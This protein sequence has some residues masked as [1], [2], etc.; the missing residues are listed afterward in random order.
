MT[1]FLAHFLFL[2]AAWTLVIKFLLPVVW[3]N[4]E[5]VPLGTYIYWDFWWAVHIWL[6]LAL[7]DQP[8]YA[9]VLALAVSV[10]EITIV[11]VKLTLFLADPD[12]TVWSMN[13]FVNKLFV[14]ACFAIILCHAL[15]RRHL[16]G[17]ARG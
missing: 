12:W 14:L 11:V 13:W 5:G 1:R 15:L 8:R 17:G 4:V 10:A 6:G 9:W 2:L 7:L 3:A 16:Y